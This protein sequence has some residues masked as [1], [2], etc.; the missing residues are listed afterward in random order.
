VDEL[1]CSEL[2]EGAAGAGAA[3]QVH[4][5]M[6]HNAE[7]WGGAQYNGKHVLG[8]GQGRSLQSAM[9]KRD[10]ALPCRDLWAQREYR[11]PA[12]MSSKLGGCEKLFTLSVPSPCFSFVDRPHQL[13]K[14]MRTTQSL[15]FFSLLSS[16]LAFVFS[17]VNSGR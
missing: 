9:A 14:Y 1:N 5:Y 3:I 4:Y 6:R 13:K 7:D 15:P 10:D 16:S 2:P 12:R 11:R 17:V 8:H